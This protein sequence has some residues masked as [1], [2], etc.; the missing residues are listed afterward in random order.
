MNPVLWNARIAVSAVER[1]RNN[2]AN[3]RLPS[4]RS[5]PP[6]PAAGQYGPNQP[7]CR[8]R[9]APA[10]RRPTKTRFQTDSYEFPQTVFAGW[11]V[12]LLAHGSILMAAVLFN[13]HVTRTPVV[14]QKESF[15][16]EVALIAAPKSGPIV[17]D[18]VQAQGAPSAAEPELQNIAD[19]PPS[20]RIR[21]GSGHQEEAALQDSLAMADSP[22]PGVHQQRSLLG[23]SPKVLE[24]AAQ[25]AAVT[26]LNSPASLLPPP[27]VESLRDSDSLQVETQLEIPTVLQRPQP[28]TRPLV[29]RAAL[30]DYTWLMDALRTKL[31]RAKVYPRS[32]KSVHAQGRVVVHVSIHGD[33]HLVNPVIEESSGYPILDQAALD[34]VRTAS[35]LKLDHP[36]EDTPVVMLVPLNYQLE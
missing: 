34:A 12:S 20:E 5:C 30:P 14:P 10:E 7:R 3:G 6:V 25:P 15:R 24:S 31:E 21:D 26:A 22:G 1:L 33:G 32:A 29:T 35:P 4:H 9:I 23:R 18:S 28:V 16:W 36:L 27:E 2:G 17:A 11:S 8:E 13:F 19:S